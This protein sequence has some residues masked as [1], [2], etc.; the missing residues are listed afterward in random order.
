MPATIFPR[1]T[2]RAAFALLWATVFAVWPALR[3]GAQAPEQMPE[4][5]KL[6]AEAW[7]NS[8]PLR[9]ADFAGQ[10][11]LIEIWTST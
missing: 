1:W 4:L 5:P 9:K 2:R 10:V 3:S 7:I 11:L 6:G 8:A